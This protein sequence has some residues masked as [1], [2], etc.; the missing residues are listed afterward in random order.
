MIIKICLIVIALALS[1]LVMLITIAFFNAKRFI[2]KINLA[3]SN[4][5]NQFEQTR[6]EALDLI[7]NT[8]RITS[9]IK[10]NI[11]SSKSLVDNTNQLLNSFNHIALSLRQISDTFTSNIENK[12]TS[13][14]VNQHEK[15][16]DVI[17][18]ASATLD[19]WKKWKT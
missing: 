18:W 1:I 6:S 13:T 16:S 14:K 7:Q 11:N 12:V 8:K 4:M 3:I 19:I 17:N 2:K 9:E 15:T 5:N 10:T